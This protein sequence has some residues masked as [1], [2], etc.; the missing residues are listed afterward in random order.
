[1]R[2]AGE[3]LRDMQS[4][5]E[6]DSGKGGDRKSRLQDA[7]VIQQSPKTLS[8]LGINKTQSSRYQA[9][10]NRGELA[11]H[12]EVGRGKGARWTFHLEKEHSRPLEA[13]TQARPA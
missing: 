7:T 3:I 13:P 9:L 10:A 5:G 6:R 8:D 11:H 4:T 2:R 1:M 12:G